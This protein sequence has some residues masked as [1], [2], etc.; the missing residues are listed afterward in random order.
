MKF[1]NLKKGLK[2]VDRWYSFSTN[3]FGIEG[4]GVITKI[5]RKNKTVD[6]QFN[7]QIHTYDQQH[8]EQFIKQHT[9][10][11]KQKYQDQVIPL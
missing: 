5:S 6:I 9:R 7:G 3:S 1:S 11:M 2:V 8:L 4:V 10:G